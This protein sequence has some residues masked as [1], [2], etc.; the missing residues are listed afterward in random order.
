MIIDILHDDGINHRTCRVNGI[1]N[2]AYGR[3]IIIIDTVTI[4]IYHYYFPESKMIIGS[5]PLN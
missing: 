5:R 1:N 3:I 4:P 2:H